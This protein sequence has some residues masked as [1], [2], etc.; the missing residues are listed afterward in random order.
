MKPRGHTS[1]RIRVQRAPTLAR[2]SQ[3]PSTVPPSLAM[4]APPLLSPAIVRDSS[5]PP[6]LS[7]RTPN[8]LS[9]SKSGSHTHIALGVMP[10]CPTGC[11]WCPLAALPVC[12]VSQ[13]AKSVAS[14][15]PMRTGPRHTH[16]FSFPGVHAMK[17]QSPLRRSATAVSPHGFI[18]SQHTN[19]VSVTSIRGASLGVEESEA[20]KSVHRSSCSRIPLSLYRR[21]CQRS[22]VS[23]E[24]RAIL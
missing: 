15:I 11:G 1:R 13:L 16:E 18:M 21:L 9:S 20:S 6:S 12:W 7:R 3:R 19:T 2:R 24:R 4:H 5:R 22:Y 17:P 8:P 14:S 23:S 10:V